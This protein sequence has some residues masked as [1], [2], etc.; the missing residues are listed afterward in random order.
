M[1]VPDPE[2]GLVIGY[3]YL[4][5]AEH[6]RGQEKG[7]KDRPCTIILTAQGAPGETVVTVLPI[8]HVSPGADEHAVEICRKLI[9]YL[10][11]NNLEDPPRVVTQDSLDANPDLNS[12]IPDDPK[13]PYDVRRVICGVV[14]L[15][16]HARG[17]GGV[18]LHEAHSGLRPELVVGE[19]AQVAHGQLDARHAQ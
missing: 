19:R 14:D 9:G 11:S 1:P 6:E 4:W 15:G 18:P 17:A 12:V 10:P 16:D 2:P 5:H 7:S 3:A 13:Q 8:T